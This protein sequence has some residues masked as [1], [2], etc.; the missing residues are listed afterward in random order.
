MKKYS[1][2]LDIG[3]SSVGWICLS[4]DYQILK[5]NNR[6]ALGVHEFEG[7]KVAADRR[8]K[9]G[10][11]RRY[12]RRK[13]RL[14]LLQQLFQ[15]PME[16]QYPN[17]FKQ[18]DSK[19]FWKNN[20]QF[21]NRT[22]SEVLR[23]L[24]TN[25][26]IYP[27]I[28]HL[29]NDLVKSKEKADLR[30]I[31][32]AIHNLVKYR[33]HFLIEGKKWTSGKSSYNMTE[34]LEYLLKKY[35][36]LIQYQQMPYNLEQLNEIQDIL[37]DNRITRQDRSSKLKSIVGKE[38]EH[39]FK[40]LLGLKTG[41][42]KLFPMSE[43]NEY[44][45]ETK[46]S[47]II[48]SEE[49]ESEIEQLTEDEIEFL[50]ILQPLYQQ[51][52]LNHLLN[53]HDC[54][55]S[56]KVASYLDF[57]K[58]LKNLKY[59]ID[60]YADNKVYRE[61][62]ITPKRNQTNYN[63]THD[64]SLLCLFDQYLKVKK[65]EDS[66]KSKIVTLLKAMIDK[67]DNS[68]IQL[69][70]EILVSISNDQFLVKQKSSQNSSI[71]HQN[72]LYEA[73]QIL[74]NQQKYYSFITE[75]F[76]KKIEQIIT[77]RIPYYI[78]PLGNSQYS[79]MIRK[80]DGNIMP[81]SFDSKIDKADSASQFIERMKNKCTYLKNEAVL[82]K[83]SLLYQ[84]YEL[85][86]ELNGIQ[87][88]ST[89][90]EPNKRYRLDT[91]VKEWI[92]ENVFKK[93]KTVTHTKLIQE[94]QKSPFKDDL[95][96]HGEEKKIF[97]TQ[98]MD[99][100]NSSLGSFITFNDIL[101][102]EMEETT[103]NII[104][105]LTV[106]TEKD[107]I[108]YKIKNTYPHITKNQIE[109]IC[110][111]KISG[112]GRL[113][114]KLLTGIPL[115]DE[116]DSVIE[117]MEKFP[118][119][120]ME[121]FT[122]TDLKEKI[123]KLNKGKVVTSNKIKYQD[124]QELAGSPALKRGIWRAIKILE[125]LVDIFG[126]PENI[127]IEVAREDQA[128]KETKSNKK[129]WEDLGKE[130][131][132]KDLKEFNK[133]MSSYPEEKFKDRRFWLY[134]IQ[135]GKCMYTGT[136]L[137]IE[138]LHLYD[139]DHI[140]PR[141][142]VKD[143]SIDNLALVLGDMNKKKNYNGQNKMPLEIIPENQHY[144]MRSYWEHLNKL[145]LISNKKLNLLLKPTFDD[146]DKEK[147]INRQ[148]VETRQ[149][150]QNVK[151]LLMERFEATNIHL[152]KAGIVSKFRKSLELP[153]IRSYNNKHHAIDALLSAILIQFITN[154]YGENFLEFNFKQ[155]EASKK[156]GRIAQNS[157]DF[158]VFRNFKDSEFKSNING[159]LVPG[160]V[161]MKEIYYHSEWQTTK[162]TGNTEKGFYK[163]MPLSPKANPK[164]YLPSEA[165]IA[166]YDGIVNDSI[167]AIEYK[168]VKKNKEATH[169]GLF[170]FRVIDG[171]KYKGLSEN[172]IAKILVERSKNINVLHAQLIRVIP[173]YQK[174]LWGEHPYYMISTS[175]LHNA[176]Q[177]Q[178]EQQLV[179]EVTSET[180]S[181][182]SIEELKELFNNI[183]SSFFEQYKIYNSDTFKNKVKQFVDNELVNTLSF[184][185]G[186]EELLKSAAA[187]ATRSD[188]FGSRLA[189][190]A[191]AD[192]IQ[193]IYES[194]TGLKYRKPQLLKTKEK[195]S[196]VRS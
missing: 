160:M 15:I 120:F 95:F 181:E 109:S 90:E 166:V 56:A 147:F 73:L 14:Q 115:N 194:I 148:L 172:E 44:Y 84:K 24:G 42:D 96:P 126:E 9:R 35:G 105:W 71:P 195:K 149:I 39:L 58:D 186:L 75:E 106:F 159:K 31:Y 167:W 48:T 85:L 49:F 176:K 32:L 155:K 68:D 111:L 114:K 72:N 23:S 143:D 145:R 51:L 21:E 19:H 179:E 141:N 190:S 137:D 119:N 157:E 183:S 4:S 7:A 184:S 70:E 69:I 116:G 133:K 168:E 140:L 87:L 47:L 79:W 158:F 146:V 125:E 136:P 50:E 174:I 78:G 178:L 13:K 129:L 107:I 94:L 161:Y 12:N 1:I 93:I 27:T 177:W 20:N 100:F 41:C 81:W 108:E 123:L 83:N 118:N 154:N 22:L 8:I 38:Y 182:K 53:G 57:E 113:S 131:T 2:G 43:K 46:K 171:Y 16:E 103:E 101:P 26:R 86:N 150:I 3:T 112:W 34:Q 192:E 134:L 128:S 54:V 18:D 153:K 102:N 76:I 30:L 185:V 99:R 104:Y 117:I 80:G 89:N 33:G 132:D 74:K 29:R 110:N 65:Y 25:S 10:T 156:W 196:L 152:V 163:E 66:F 77:F 144:A 98:K 5:Y 164:K 63:K 91:E 67:A 64:H 121:I 193:L 40:L 45:K 162:M 36:E 11:R 189:K 138:Q 62:F 92:I 17:F 187:N 60:K 173:K 55:S 59:L 151:D 135:Q 180:F 165:S 170:D 130:W 37:I 28:Y 169:F 142:F 188:K 191:K 88:R 124:I 175:E 97:G 52:S 6:L 139:V 122:F 127:I 61:I 82:P